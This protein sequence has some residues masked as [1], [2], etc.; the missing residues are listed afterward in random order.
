MEKLHTQALV[1]SRCV[2]LQQSHT[3]R[4]ESEHSFLEHLMTTALPQ[5]D[6]R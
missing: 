5:F 2:V 4:F 3:E 1:T 6:G